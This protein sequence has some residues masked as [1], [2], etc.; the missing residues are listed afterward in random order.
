MGYL[1]D[2]SNPRGN[3][4]ILASIT[5][6]ET[7]V[8]VILGQ[9][10]LMGADNVE[11]ARANLGELRTNCY[12]VRETLISMTAMREDPNS[13][14]FDETFVGELDHIFGGI[15]FSAVQPC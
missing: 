1:I 13:D 2:P 8:M 4:S 11:E 5:A 9:V 3:T 10:S 15:H 14:I 6:L 12:Q 7:V